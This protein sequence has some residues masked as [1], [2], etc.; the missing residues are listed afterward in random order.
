M[1]RGGAA[2]QDDAE[3]LRRYAEANAEEAIAEFVRRNLGLGYHAG[4][5]QCGRA[6]LRAED[7]AQA[8]FTDLARKAEKLAGRP[9]LAGW[10][11][12]STRLAAAQAAALVIR[13]WAAAQGWKDGIFDYRLRGWRGYRPVRRRR[14]G[15][16]ETIGRSPQKTPK[17]A[18][19]DG[20]FFVDSTWRGERE[21]T[22]ESEFLTTD[23][24]R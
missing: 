12:T 17:G 22:V 19:M 9:A 2:R 7:V 1:H 6:A 16:A 15:R 4:L 14:L 10:L 13:M 8:V 5:R 11:H 23:G 3:W 20:F 18:K 24:H 21:L